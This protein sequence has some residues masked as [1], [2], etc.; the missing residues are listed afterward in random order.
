MDSNNI[1]TVR[2]KGRMYHVPKVLYDTDERNGDRA[3]Y[4]AK[5]EPKDDSTYVVLQ[6]E[7][8]RWCNEKYMGMKYSE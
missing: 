8:A 5:K 2:F 3:W 4:I 7:A 1:V 6:D